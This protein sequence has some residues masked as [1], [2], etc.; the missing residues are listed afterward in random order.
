MSI[1]AEWHTQN[2]MPKNASFEQRV[3]WHLAHQ[4]HCTCAPIPMRLLE[5]MERKGISSEPVTKLK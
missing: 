5:E 2:K 3:A 4:Q 1:N